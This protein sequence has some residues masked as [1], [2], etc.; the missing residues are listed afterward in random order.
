V[1]S[2]GGSNVPESPKGC[3]EK[4]PPQGNITGGR[5][6]RTPSSRSSTGPPRETRVE[7]PD[8]SPAPRSLPLHP[9]R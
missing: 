8:R 7:R 2:R 3:K 5:R 6:S 1:P 4:R 9:A